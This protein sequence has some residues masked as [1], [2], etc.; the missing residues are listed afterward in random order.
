MVSKMFHPQ[1]LAAA[2]SQYLAVNQIY[3]YAMRED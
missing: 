3:H 2:K 1:Y